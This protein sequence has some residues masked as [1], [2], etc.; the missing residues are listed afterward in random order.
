MG[1]FRSHRGSNLGPLEFKWMF[2]P[3]SVIHAETGGV[4]ANLGKIVELSPDKTSRVRM[5]LQGA[6]IDTRG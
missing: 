1:L 3:V 5:Y 2:V 4:G 6:K